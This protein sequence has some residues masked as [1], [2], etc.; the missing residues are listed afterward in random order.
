MMI[1]YGRQS[2]D[3][4]DIEA[5]LTVLKS[6]YLT[7]GPV[8]P[9]FEA[10]VTDYCGTRHGVAVNSAT[11]AL[12]IACMALDVGPGDL[13]WTSPISFVASANCARYC[14]ADVDFVDI[15]PVS[16][17]MSVEALEAKL[18]AADKAGRLPKVLIP[19][20][21]T[22]EPCAMAEIATLARH[23]GIAIIADAAHAIGARHD[24]K[25]VGYGAYADITV[26]SFHPV[27][28]VTTAEGGMAMTSNDE[29]ARHM[30]LARNHGVT[31][32]AG[33]MTRAPDGPWYYEQLS[34][35]YNYRMTE[36]QAA[37]G[38]SQ[39]ARIDAFIER[40]HALARRYDE[41]LA[42]LPL[43]L[44]RRA[45]ANLSALHL[46][47][48]RLPTG[49][50][51]T[52]HRAVFEA[53][54]EAGIGVNLHYIPIHLQPYY[55]ALGFGEGHCPE[56]ERYYREAITLPLYPAMSEAEQDRIIAALREVLQ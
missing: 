6:D 38:L 11:S 50:I 20:H 34:L 4:A 10:Q 54:H 35:G 37:L 5:V 53:L 23:Y 49:E 16:W 7:Q 17:N 33:M 30:R 56:A 3:E 2:I 45:P 28:I 52:S 25:P 48:V 32:D 41:K 12:H 39:M 40:R 19:V 13:V 47:V 51:A 1:P 36:L 14:G 22:G 8:V 26:F 21:F 42:D 9:R 29:L 44:P 27:K 31:R 18:R 43:T 24:G 55:R 46:Y 15:D